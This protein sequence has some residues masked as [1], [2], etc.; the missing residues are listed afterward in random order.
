M[1]PDILLAIRCKK[2]LSVADMDQGFIFPDY[3]SQVVVSY[4]QAASVATLAAYAKMGGDSPDVLMKLAI[5]QQE[6]GDKA[7]AARTLDSVN[8]IY[9]ENEAQHRRF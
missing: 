1:T 6:L 7:A 2:L 4:F 8:F 3:A 9:P 5:W